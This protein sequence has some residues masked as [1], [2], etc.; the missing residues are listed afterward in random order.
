MLMIRDAKVDDELMALNA[1]VPSSR[2]VLVSAHNGGGVPHADKPMRASITNEA[3]SEPFY[4][5]I[6]KSWQRRSIDSAHRRLLFDVFH[7]QKKLVV[8][9][10]MADG[11]L[12]CAYEH[13]GVE[14]ARIYWVAETSGKQWQY[15]VLHTVRGR[16]EEWSR[17]H[18][19]IVSSALSRIRNLFEHESE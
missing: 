4:G 12:K 13:L 3:Y 1:R 11:D 10:T 6:K 9:D 5:G 14:T 19:A 7:G 2:A 15:L 18:G 17:E 8:T 16:E